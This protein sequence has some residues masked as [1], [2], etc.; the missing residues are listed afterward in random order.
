MVQKQ[1]FV[2]TLETRQ[3]LSATFANMLGQFSGLLTFSGGTTDSEVLL[4][5]A[6]KNG[7]FS[8]QVFQGS[9]AASKT[10][11]TVNKRGVIHTTTHGTNVKF[12]STFIGAITGDTIVGSFVTRQGKLKLTGVVSLSRTAV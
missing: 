4:V 10:K 7:S 12:S 1:C 9:G 5:V 8:G 11:G 3:L 2:E 6:Q